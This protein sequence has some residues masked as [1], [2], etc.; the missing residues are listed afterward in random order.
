MHRIAVGGSLMGALFAVGIVLIFAIGVPYGDW[1]LIASILAGTC[2]SA[3]LYAW[4]EKHPVEL[5]DLHHPNRTA[6]QK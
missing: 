1:F 2:V 4:H 5:V 6:G 3:V